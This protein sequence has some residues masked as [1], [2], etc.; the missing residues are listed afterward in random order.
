MVLTETTIRQTP[1]NAQ[2]TPVAF[3]A[4][5][6]IQYAGNIDEMVKQLGTRNNGLYTNEWLMGDAKNNEIAMYELGTAH[7]KLWRSSKNEWFGNTP[8]FYWG[9]NNAKDLTIRTEYLPDPQGQPEY[10]PFTPT[11]RDLA[12]QDLYKK[13][14]GQI[15]EQFAYLAFRSAPLVS[16]STMDAKVITADMAKNMMVW[17]AIGKP[18]QRE[19]LPGGRSTYEKNDGIY[20][21]GY[22][23][24]S[25]AIEQDRLAP[26]PAAAPAPAVQRPARPAANALKERLWKGW[27]IPA[28]EADTWFAAGSAAY[29]SLLQGDEIDKA[30]EA[31]R[32]QY[33][34]LKLASENEMTRFRT[35]ETKGVLFLDSLRRKLGDDKFLALM[36]GFFDANTTRT[37]TAQSFLDK[38]GV[39]FDFVEPADGPAYTVSDIG[40]RLASALIVYGTQREAGA[41]RYAAEQLQF[42]YLNQYESQVPIYKDFE[43][44]DELLAHKD[45]IFV[46]R[47]EANMALAEWAK[48]I[49]LEYQGAMFTIDKQ[50]HATEREALT[51]AAKN[52]LDPAHMVLV[53]AGNDALRTVKLATSGSARFEQVPYVITGE[54][55][56]APAAPTGGR[57]QR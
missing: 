34:G 27:I 10:V 53:L 45:V 23:L 11:V 48:A 16:A 33:R 7:T 18:N 44:T 43:V 49:H 13:Y 29:H 54:A 6:A 1:F 47:P 32:I 28:S 20:P 51:L 25:T 46:G 36:Q 38:A 26:K 9:N 31:R 42:A 56:R 40:R 30:I 52:P 12:W 41:N 2:G 22:A 5:M 35:E 24:F 21:S 15:D 3:R 17:A 50:V 37:V 19:W 39:A 4:R 8:G 57:R 55:T 14:R